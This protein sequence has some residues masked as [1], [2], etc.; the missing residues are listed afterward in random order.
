MGLH[1]QVYGTLNARLRNKSDNYAEVT[2]NILFEVTVSFS[3]FIEM[4]CVQVLGNCGKLHMKMVIT[5]RS[6]NS[7]GPI[8]L[9]IGVVAISGSS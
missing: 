8:L 1:G 4:G 3:S 7:S 5:C 9:T 6:S 2:N